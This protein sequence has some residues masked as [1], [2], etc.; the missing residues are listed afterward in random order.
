MT[1]HMLRTRTPFR[2]VIALV[3][4]EQSIILLVLRIIEK[5]TRN[6]TRKPEKHQR[7]TINRTSHHI[8]YRSKLNSGKKLIILT[9]FDSQFPLSK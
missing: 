4:T 8:C 3:G 7:N 1:H 5:Q 2:D 9:W 6:L